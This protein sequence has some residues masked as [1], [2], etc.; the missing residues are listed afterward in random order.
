M[1]R[2]AGSARAREARPA[3]ARRLSAEVERLRFEAAAQLLG[4]VL[5]DPAILLEHEEAFAE[6]ELDS[7]EG[8]A[9]RREILHW[10]AEGGRLDRESLHD[11]L[12]RYGFGDLVERM[13]QHPPAS[14]DSPSG[15][16]PDGWLEV[17]ARCV[18]RARRQRDIRSLTDL[19][20]RRAVTGARAVPD[21][22][23]GS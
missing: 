6:A 8:E 5:R 16:G 15:D 13:L 12:C 23:D 18:A 14:L 3:G 17:L 1:G 22:V 7:P 11:H 21:D 9:L 10:L 2:G 4:P 20:R 19:V